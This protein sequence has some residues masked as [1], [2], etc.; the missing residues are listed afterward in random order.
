MHA[1]PQANQGRRAWLLRC[2]RHTAVANGQLAACEKR[3]GIL[4]H[5]RKL[6]LPDRLAMA[7]IW[8][9]SHRR[10]MR[11][12]RRRNGS[13]GQVA[14]PLTPADVADLVCIGTSCQQAISCSRSPA[15]SLPIKA[16]WTVHAGKRKRMALTDAGMR[17]QSVR[18]GSHAQHHAEEGCNPEEAGKQSSKPARRKQRKQKLRQVA[19][20]YSTTPLMPDGT[21]A[22]SDPVSKQSP[23]VQPGDVAAASIG[24]SDAACIAHAA[25]AAAPPKRRRCDISSLCPP[26]IG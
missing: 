14:S 8:L 4:L 20:L 10:K 18:D 17:Q 13:C 24:G 15:M 1:L 25:E 2:L 23:I 22:C 11:T 16:V 3:A 7:L 6:T 12:R 9:P 26:G 21:A 5:Q 19:E